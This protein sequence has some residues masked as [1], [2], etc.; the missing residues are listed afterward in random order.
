MGYFS[1]VIM[2]ACFLGIG[3]GCLLADKK[4]DLLNFFPLALF[5]SLSI[6]LYFKFETRISSPLMIYFTEYWR[7]VPTQKVESFFLLPLIFTLITGLFL[8]LSQ[9][10]GVL[11]KTLPPL[12]AY[13]INIIGGITGI[14][15]FSVLSFLFAKPIIWFL[16]LVLVLLPL[17]TRKGPFFIIN[18]AALALT[19]LLVFGE[20]LNTYWSPYYKITFEPFPGVK[21]ARIINVNNIGHQ[22]LID[23][24][25]K[26][27]FYNFPYTLSKKPFEDVLI[28]G[29]GCGNDTAA[30]L[31][32]GVKRIDAVEID[33][34]ILSLGK[35]VHPNLPYLHKNVSAFV[36]DGRAFLKRSKSRYDL[37]VYGLI[38]S[39]TLTSGFSNVRLENYL[40]TLESFKEAKSHLK[41]G[42]AL[43]IYNYFREEWLV[44]KLATMLKEAFGEAPYVYISPK[45][46]NFAILVASEN[47]SQFSFASPGKKEIAVLKPSTDDW[48]FIYLR[49]PTIPKIYV[50]ALL[51]ILA[52]S[53]FLIYFALGKRKAINPHFFFLG[54]GFMLLETENI[55]KFSLLF[56]STWLVNSLVITAILLVALLAVWAANR[57]KK[58]NYAFIYLLLFVF[59]AAGYMI[60]YSRLLLDNYVMR[61]LAVSF[62]AFS[63]LF[64]AGIIFAFSLKQKK[65]IAFAFGANL[66]GAMVGGI[67]EYLSLGFGYQ[68]L[69]FAIVIFYLLSLVFLRQKGEA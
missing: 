37:I 33:P 23:V 10:L 5:G 15:V 26:E 42:G 27:F 43:V 36:N 60:P 63:P 34:F 40:F 18:L 41:K 52:L 51:I 6:I 57:I 4:R 44:D 47:N 39:L 45:N 53:I 31:F 17:L 61:Y 35:T 28:L 22:D 65:D 56:G 62:L 19:L 7:Q 67:T 9:R 58:L 20:G 25:L 11:L 14:A 32:H 49:K 8:L 59:L 3:A 46:V 13:A 66:L 50:K 54:A 1:N 69:Q 2:L 21:N 29:A 48:P 38:D 68:S 16:I 12:K 24:R 30:A 55:I 64:A